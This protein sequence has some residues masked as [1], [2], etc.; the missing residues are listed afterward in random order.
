MPCAFGGPPLRG[1]LRTSPEDFRVDEQLGF[2]PTGSGEH[3][4]LWIEK[5]GTNTDWLAGQ[6]ARFAGVA[7]MAVGYSGLKDRHAVT[8]QYFT[9]HLPGCADPEWTDLALDGVTVLEATRHNRKLKRGSHRGNRF[10]I[11]LREVQGD[12][13][14]AERRIATLRERG[15]PNYFGEQRFGHDGRNIALA[16]SLFRGR[17]LGRAQRSI[18]LS[19]ARSAI[20]NAVLARR[21][22]E[23]SWE[24]VLTGEV[25]MLA[26]SNAIFGPVP[27]DAEIVTRHA[28]RDI[29]ATG[30]LWG[31][32][33]L[34]SEDE[35][36]TLETE[37][38]DAWRELA[39]GL[40]AADLKQERRRLCLVVAD[41]SH[42]W[43]DAATLELTFSLPSGTYATSVLAELCDWHVDTP[44]PR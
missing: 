23:Q 32:G 30:P 9:V 20:F 4:F 10:V 8:R 34:R 21:V 36:L 7:P 33:A 27:L 11:R 29:Q 42:A 2:D 22:R 31:A 5:T 43:P 26:T 15:V 6:I 28:A 25:W 12:R 35:V 24:R 18:A 41:L 38:V 40:A 39:D 19:S 13:A 16:Q 37:V 14:E 3:A 44:D 17:R 1:R